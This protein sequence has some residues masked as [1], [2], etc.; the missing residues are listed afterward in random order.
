[1]AIVSENYLTVFFF[2]P[3]QQEVNALK[4]TRQ[5]ESFVCFD[6]FFFALTFFFLNGFSYTLL[7]M[8]AIFF[9]AK[10]TDKNKTK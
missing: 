1:M 4:F 6:F 10:Q 5:P 3:K 7:K 2:V 8:H 9:N